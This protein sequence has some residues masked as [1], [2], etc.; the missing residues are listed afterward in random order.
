LA[1]GAAPPARLTTLVLPQSLGIWLAS[2]DQNLSAQG[3]AAW[4]A[5]SYLM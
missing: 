1:A 2:Y 5:A 4:G 3:E